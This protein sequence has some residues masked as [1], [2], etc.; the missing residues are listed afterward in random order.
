MKYSMLI[1][2]LVSFVFPC[3]LYTGH[4]NWKVFLSQLTVITLFS[5]IFYYIVGF[6]KWELVPGITFIAVPLFHGLMVFFA[7]QNFVIKAKSFRRNNRI[8]LAIGLMTAL[9][10]V[11]LG[12]GLKESR[13]IEL[14][15]PFALLV[16][17]LAIFINCFYHCKR[18]GQLYSPLK[19]VY[20]AMLFFWP[21]LLFASRWIAR[22]I[23]HSYGK[24]EAL[25]FLYIFFGIIQALANFSMLYE[26]TRATKK[27]RKV[28][29]ERDREIE[30]RTGELKAKGARLEERT[31]QLERANRELELKSGEIELV[32]RELERKTAELTEANRKLTI[33]NGK[34]EEQTIELHK[35][36]RSL[37]EANIKLRE[38]Y[39]RRKN[40]FEYLSHELL[41]PFSLLRDNLISLGP[42]FEEEDPKYRGLCS[43]VNRMGLFFTNM[44]KLEAFERG[45]FCH[46]HDRALDIAAF[47]REK[48]Y[49]SQ[50]TL[51]RVGKRLKWKV[52]SAEIYVKIDP[53]ALDSILNNLITNGARYAPKGSELYLE[54]KS[55]TKA[56]KL[57]VSNPNPGGLDES[58]FRKSMEPFV[59][60]EKG[61][62][63][64]GLGLSLVEGTIKQL[65]GAS[66]KIRAT[67]E[68]VRS[69][70]ILPTAG[71]EEERVEKPEVKGLEDIE[72]STQYELQPEPL[73]DEKKRTILVVE[74]SI[75]M[76]NHYLNSL[77]SLYNIFCEQSGRGA[78]KRLKRLDGA[79]HPDL[80]I[81]DNKMEE[82]TGLELCRKLQKSK[83]YRTIPL[84][85]ISAKA[86]LES[87]LEGLRSGA[88]D[89]IDK[90]VA[91]EEVK[92]KVRNI[93]EKGEQRERAGFAGALSKLE[94]LEAL[95][96]VGLPEMEQLFIKT[97]LNCRKKGLS[98]SHRVIAEVMGISEGRSKGLTQRIKEK[99]NPILPDDSQLYD[100]DGILD[101]FSQEDKGEE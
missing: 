11:A 18:E 38:N 8:I 45:I 101:Y 2:F 56:V 42:H 15:Q 4:R 70:I 53:I 51:D 24:D 9:F 10:L 95:E 47:T 87:R 81:S 57:T 54:L 19:R 83:E 94:G 31:A 77:S 68:W 26:V 30:E 62:D 33:L 93:L 64:L 84:I 27:L 67:E 20:L 61:P 90:P 41:T 69:E 28:V 76:L 75:P 85:L 7:G 44:L 36:N 43:E 55:S 50:P 22:A 98:T 6:L 48:A 21:L 17:L 5:A 12:V 60:K 73:Y 14:Y 32:N 71:E 1:I 40:Y 97:G 37:G 92:E 35:A 91:M 34:M 86:D 49:L 46:N 23:E 52:P 72:E 39:N 99:L 88:V 65:P 16:H 74:D 100:K 58:Y 3:L 82:M 89:Y 63:G 80:I 25:T 79:G 29:A 96:K 78:L 13:F 66:F 59:R